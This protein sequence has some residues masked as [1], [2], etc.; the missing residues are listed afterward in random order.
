VH[1]HRAIRAGDDH[2]VMEAAGTLLDQRDRRAPTR[3]VRVEISQGRLAGAAGD[4]LPAARFGGMGQHIGA[5]AAFGVV[6]ERREL[7]GAR[8][9]VAPVP[10]DHRERRAAAEIRGLRDVWHEQRPRR[11]GLSLRGNC[12]AQQQ[13]RR[14]GPG[15]ASRGGHAQSP[16]SAMSST[17]MMISSSVV[18]EI[19]ITR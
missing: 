6:H 14:R 8:L 11:R 19:T 16:Q 18:T 5:D 12:R 10:E 4:R 9:A 13:H 17:M 2:D 1:D 3:D 7:L 15:E